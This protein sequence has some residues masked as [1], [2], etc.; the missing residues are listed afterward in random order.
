MIHYVAIFDCFSGFS[1]CSLFLVLT[2]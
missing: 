2:L 1:V